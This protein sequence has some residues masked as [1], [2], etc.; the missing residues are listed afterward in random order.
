MKTLSKAR[1]LAAELVDTV[2]AERRVLEAV[3]SLPFIVR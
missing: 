1:M 2:L 3:N